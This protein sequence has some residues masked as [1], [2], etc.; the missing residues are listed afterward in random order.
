MTSVMPHLFI[1]QRTSSPLKDELMCVV[2]SDFLDDSSSAK[3][4]ADKFLLPVQST[5]L[6]AFE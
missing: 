3:P 5:V 6:Y 4:K 2:S 1:F